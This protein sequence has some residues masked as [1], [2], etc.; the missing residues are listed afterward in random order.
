MVKTRVIGDAHGK[1]VQYAEIAEGAD[2]S[3]QVGDMGVGFLPEAM[4]ENMNEWYVNNGMT[5]KFIRGNHDNPEKCKKMFGW[6]N[7]GLIINDIMFIGGAWSIDQAYRVEGVSWWRDEE[8]SYSELALLV[9]T[10]TYM[11]PRVM[12]T[13]DCPE[14]VSQKMFIDAGLSLGGDVS[15]PTRT[16][17]AFDAMFEIHKPKLWIFGH[18]HVSAMEKIEGTKFICLDE[19]DFID[20]DLDLKWS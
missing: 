2:Q 20:V 18:W 15:H 10:Y 8:L 4:N 16:G 14:R 3:I 19:L 9:E 13:H 5:H 6:I 12:I 17:Q 7:D 1:W 11:K